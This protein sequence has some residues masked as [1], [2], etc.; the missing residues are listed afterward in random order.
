MLGLEILSGFGLFFLGGGLGYGML[1]F[2]ILFGF[3]FN[4]GGARVWN[5][6]V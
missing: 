6:R 1:G 2:E 5:F 4:L 3:W